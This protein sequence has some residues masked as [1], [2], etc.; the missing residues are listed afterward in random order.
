[1]TPIIQTTAFAGVAGL[2]F[3]RE[4]ARSA[5]C[6]PGATGTKGHTGAQTPEYESSQDGKKEVSYESFGVF[7]S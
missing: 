5:G 1:M 3:L 6:M 4:T 2:P 7:R